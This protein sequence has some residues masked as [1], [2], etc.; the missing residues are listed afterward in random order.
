M[1]LTK[2]Y[3]VPG[4]ALLMLAMPMAACQA[5]GS[6][7]E[8]EPAELRLVHA[9]EYGIVFMRT[10]DA[11]RM[12]PTEPVEVT[13]WNFFDDADSL[14]KSWGWNTAVSRIRIDC[15]SG[16]MMALHQQAYLGDTLVEEVTP[17]VGMG[18]PIGVDK[19][20]VLEFV[21]R[22][23]VETGTVTAADVA[24]ARAWADRAFTA[25]FDETP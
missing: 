10:A 17:R 19:V 22:P 1:N 24:T 12:A 23:R 4:L 16:T 20:A 7:A 9:D 21:C 6:A 15:P 3:V 2:W 5:Q 8:Q 14:T 13:T 25:G 11:R 18:P